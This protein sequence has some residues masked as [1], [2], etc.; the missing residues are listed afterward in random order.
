MIKISNLEFIRNGHVWLRV[1]EFDCHQGERVALVGPSGAGKTSLLRSM[2][3]HIRPDQGLIETQQ[4][5][6]MLFQKPAL[7]RCSVLNNLRI[8]AFLAGLSRHDGLKRSLH[9][10]ER[11]EIEP[12]APL[13]AYRLS[14]GQQQRVAFARAML[15]PVQTVLLDEPGANLDRQAQQRLEACLDRRYTVVFSSHDLQQVLRW[16]DR[17]YEIDNG[18]LRERYGA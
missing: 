14:G 11:L 9:W 2:L 7:L 10:L 4:S 8:A 16:A 5:A 12:L 6:T 15:K 18:I 13:Q 1:P 17:V 3:G